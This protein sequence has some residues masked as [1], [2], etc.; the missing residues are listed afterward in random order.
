MGLLLHRCL[1][2]SFLWYVDCLQAA[3]PYYFHTKVR[4]HCFRCVIASFS[5]QRKAENLGGYGTHNGGR[6]TGWKA[7]YKQIAYI[8]MANTETKVT[9]I[10]ILAVFVHRTTI[11]I[12]VHCEEVTKR[13][14]YTFSCRFRRFFFHR[15]FQIISLSFP[16][17]KLFVHF[18]TL[19]VPFSAFTSPPWSW[20]SQKG[21]CK[22]ATFRNGSISAEL[23]ILP[24][25]VSHL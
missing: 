16:Y 6:E 4:C 2:R 19:S 22:I 5:A 20:R 9:V 10:N 15:P 21:N 8:F 17:Q 18:R 3:S 12:P 11:G 7:K 1:P 14:C 23:C 25:E 24:K 13:D